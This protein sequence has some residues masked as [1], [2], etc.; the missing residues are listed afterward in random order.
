MTGML[1]LPAVLILLS[2][3]AGVAGTR[4]I[5]LLLLLLR[6]V[7]VLLLLLLI[8]WLLLLLVVRGLREASVALLL[9]T[10]IGLPGMLSSGVVLSGVILRHRENILYIT[11]C[12]LPVKT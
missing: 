12:Q 2:P 5:L 8:V 9:V 7:R 10:S 6:L 3:V 1:L 11:R 4:I